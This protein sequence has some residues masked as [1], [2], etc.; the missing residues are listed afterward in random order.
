MNE[1]AKVL[2]IVRRMAVLGKLPE[3]Y[4]QRVLAITGDTPA[5]VQP[6]WKLKPRPVAEAVAAVPGELETATWDAAQWQEWAAAN[7][8]RLEQAFAGADVAIDS[9]SP[10]GTGEYVAIDSTSPP[11]TGEYRPAPVAAL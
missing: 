11:G 4:N 2:K 8:V 10:P 3:E 9:T 7:R 5:T 1:L 6:K